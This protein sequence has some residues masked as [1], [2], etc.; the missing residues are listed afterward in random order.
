[1]LIDFEK[2]LYYLFRKKKRIDLTCEHQHPTASKR[3]LNPHTAE[4]RTTIWESERFKRKTKAAKR[5]P[6]EEQHCHPEATLVTARLHPDCIQAE[7]SCPELASP[8]FSPTWCRSHSTA[9]HSI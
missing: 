8:R 4:L 7:L 5:H 2:A 9:L 3:C 1:V 6:L